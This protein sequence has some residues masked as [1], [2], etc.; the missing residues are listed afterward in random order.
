MADMYAYLEVSLVE[1]GDGLLCA[2]CHG[3]KGE[4][5][6]PATLTVLGDE[7]IFLQGQNRGRMSACCWKGLISAKDPR[8]LR[9]DTH[10]LPELTEELAQIIS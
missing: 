4:A 10:H 8:L 7:C 2:V 9:K 5:A 1:A 6:R 3:H